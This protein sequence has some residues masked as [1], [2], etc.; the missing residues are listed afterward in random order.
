MDHI[1]NAN[2]SF[3]IGSIDRVP[4]SAILEDINNKLRWYLDVSFESDYVILN[5]E[6]R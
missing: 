3:N 6:T 5:N 2:T 1:E 4:V